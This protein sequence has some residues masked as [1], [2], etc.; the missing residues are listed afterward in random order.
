MNI[1]LWQITLILLLTL[2]TGC[3]RKNFFAETPLVDQT[4]YEKLKTAPLDVDSVTVKAGKHYDRSFVHNLF[5]GKHYRPVWDAPVTV[6]VFDMDSTKG[7]LSFVK[8]GG[9]YQTTSMTLKDEEG[10]LYALRSIDKDPQKVL[11][12]IWRDT[13][14]LNI[15]RDQTS[16]ANPYGAF[17]IPP[18]A[19]AAGIPHSNPKLVYVRPNDNSFGENKDRFSNRLF[20]IEEKF[21]DDGNI[22]PSLGNAED[23]VSSGNMLNNRF[24]D[25]D[26]FI[27]QVSFAKARLLDILVNDWD[28]HEGQWEWAEYDKNGEHYYRPIPKDRDNVFFRFQDGIFPWLFSRNWGIR[29][30]ES[31]DEDF[32]DVYALAINS[33]FIDQRALAGLNRQ[34]FDSLAHEL[35]SAVTDSVISEAVHRFPDSVYKLVG[36]SIKEDLI[37]RRDKLDK[38]ANKFYEILAK[39]ALVVG[40]D[41]EEIFEVNRLDNER[42]EVI[43]KRGSDKKVVYHRIFLRSETESITLHGLAEDDKFFVN[44]KVGKGIKVNIFGGRGEDEITD[45]SD[46]KGWKNKTWVYDTKR[47]TVLN[48]GP[49][50]K[51]KRTNDVRI[52]AFDREGF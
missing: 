8:L 43:V 28:R 41:Q 15:L 38:A 32:N 37:S 1:R 52:H 5:W 16:A 6:P 10:N 42:T 24:E 27:D 25:N 9:G 4:V 14:V 50:T 7:G 47:G 40:T 29:K 45:T 17:A 23:I 13:F 49:T 35:Q 33:K 12:K 34:Q 36:E 18:L 46:V 51:D 48:G 19:N 26:H 44:G 39:D 11:P 30:F 21:D 3:V 22:P 31:F 20:M 2:S